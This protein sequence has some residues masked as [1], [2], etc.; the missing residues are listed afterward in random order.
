MEYQKTGKY[1][2]VVAGSLETLA[3]AELE[4]FGALVL[5]EV[6]RG[7]RFQCTPEQL[8]RIVYGSRLLQR[9]LAPL[10]SFRCHSEDYLYKQARQALD[11]TRL[12]TPQESFGIESNVHRSKINHSLYAGQLL[13]DAICD[14]FRDKHGIRPDFSSKAPDISFNLHIMDNWATISLDL[15]GSLHKRGYR[16]SAGSAPLQET[17]AAALVRLSKWQG[18]RPLQ[19]PMC[20]SGTIL[21]EALMHYA[22]IPAAY[23]RQDMGIKRLPDFDPSLWQKVRTEANA[24][25][26]ELPPGLISGSDAS[27]EAVDCARANLSLLPGGQ[28]VALQVSR[29]QDLPPRPGIC[30]ITNPP[31]GVRLGDDGS[32][33]KLYNDLG[34]Y[35][36]QKHPQ[37]EAY[38]LCGKQE[39]VPA[40]R[41]RAYWKKKLKNGDLD[42]V[43]ARIVLR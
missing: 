11:W 17:L 20:G 22:R 12:F 23:L 35:L 33:L 26:R 13:K 1:F 6:P 18:E 40:L 27:P 3:K 28:N 42:V 34:D 31:Y 25:I 16:L 36:K 38:I 14:A 41:L 29:F 10:V 19:D 32:I 7:M 37:S 21:A 9:V 8:Y 15:T 30:V 2:A 24:Q 39:L 4:S 5:Q 43:L